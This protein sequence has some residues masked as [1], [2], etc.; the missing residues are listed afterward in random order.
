MNN[1]DKSNSD[2]IKSGVPSSMGTC[3]KYIIMYWHL[4]KH[5][6]YNTYSVHNDRHSNISEH[7]TTRIK[8]IV[9]INWNIK[10]FGQ[11]FKTYLKTYNMFIIWQFLWCCFYRVQCT[12]TYTVL[13]RSHSVKSEFQLIGITITLQTPF[14]FINYVYLGSY[15]ISKLAKLL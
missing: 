11:T 5:I 12:C 6:I 8:M 4:C 15:T 1:C 10:N 13:I 9:T 2:V 14:R 3:H 7:K